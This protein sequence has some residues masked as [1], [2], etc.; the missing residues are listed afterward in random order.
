MSKGHQ[1]APVT[2][3]KAA[4]STQNGKGEEWTK[5]GKRRELWKPG[6]RPI[7]GYLF[8]IT[9]VKLGKDMKEAL[10]IRTIEVTDCH[11]WNKDK[12]EAEL[13]DSLPGEE[14]IVALTKGLEE[15]RPYA[16]DPDKVYKVYIPKGMKKKLDGGHT[17]WDFTGEDSIRV[18]A[19]PAK[20]TAATLV[21]KFNPTTTKDETAADARTVGSAPE[22]PIGE[23]DETDDIPF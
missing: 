9:G 8:G 22:A 13:R 11:A 4:A 16:N 7:T 1:A 19:K 21:A 20:R 12:K 3:T 18:A 2:E 6:G 15:L 10:V 14:L 17:F 5:L 23:Q